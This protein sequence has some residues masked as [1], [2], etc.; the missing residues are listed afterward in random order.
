M[1]ENASTE[2]IILNDILQFR[3]TPRRDQPFELNA[4]YVIEFV[5]TNG[6]GNETA[7]AGGVGKTTRLLC[8]VIRATIRTLPLFD[9]SGGG[10]AAPPAGA[11]MTDTWSE[12]RHHLERG[13]KLF[14]VV[15]VAG[16]V[17]G[18]IHNDWWLASIWLVAG[19]LAGVIGTPVN[20]R[21]VVADTTED[22][23]FV[24]EKELGEAQKF[25]REF[26]E[27]SNLL[28]ATMLT[29]GF[30][31]GLPWWSSLLMATLLWIASLFGIPVLCAPGNKEERGVERSSSDFA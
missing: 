20:Q 12:A 26:L 27:F 11:P 10:L 3:V 17:F 1:V 24:S 22:D 16:T 29:V 19:C 15:D 31:L 7:E 23:E 9:I 18:I 28:A 25:A 21:I 4:R 2:A 13:L 6:G 5:G 8:P 14:V 30:A